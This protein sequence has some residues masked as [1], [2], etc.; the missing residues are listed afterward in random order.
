M[1]Y[2][3]HTLE[4]VVDLNIQLHLLPALKLKYKDIFVAVQP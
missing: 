1:Q 2:T 4:G 3:L